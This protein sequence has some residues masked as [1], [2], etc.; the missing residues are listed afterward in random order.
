[1]ATA[2]GNI[3]GSDHEHLACTGAASTTFHVEV[4]PG[5]KGLMLHMEQL[6]AATGTRVGYLNNGVSKVTI[7]QSDTGNPN[8]KAH[9]ISFKRVVNGEDTPFST[10][11][12][13]MA[14]P[15]VVPPGEE[16]DFPHSNSAVVAA[17]AI[18]AAN[19]GVL[20]EIT[21]ENLSYKD[22]EES[23]RLAD[24]RARLYADNLGSNSEQLQAEA[25]VAKGGG[26]ERHAYAAPTTMYRLWDRMPE[27]QRAK[28]FPAAHV[29]IP[30]SKGVIGPHIVVDSD[31]AKRIADDTAKLLE[32][33]DG[34]RI[35]A[36]PVDGSPPTGESV[37]FHFTLH[38]HTLGEKATPMSTQSAIASGSATPNVA[39][40][41]LGAS[42]KT[43]SAVASKA[44]VGPGGGE[45]TQL[46]SEGVTAE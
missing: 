46:A 5:P 24:V 6:A 22:D 33:P 41:I 35:T 13:V 36:T 40:A 1:M 32:V 26:V 9:A 17:H 30:N 10:G 19:G 8:D 23:R 15:K 39:D 11:R 16:D 45:I 21:H 27:A 42:I 2:V 37:K 18:M 38:R 34:L 4:P 14:Q 7:H 28:V 3:G 25:T 29:E 43:P 31:V 20:S 12:V 44:A